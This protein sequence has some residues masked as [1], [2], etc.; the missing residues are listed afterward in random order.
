MVWAFLAV[1]A[2]YR[3]APLNENFQN[4]NVIESALSAKMSFR[5]MV[6]IV[7]GAIAINALLFSQS[8]HLDKFLI[9][10][11][12]WMWAAYID[13]YLVMSRYVYLPDEI[14]A[15]I[16]ILMRPF[17]VFLVSWMAVESHLRW[18]LK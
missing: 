17:V 2:I 4:L 8:R 1:I 14:Y 10:L 11:A 9:F 18:L 15:Q 13:D 16:L 7:V 12:S 6:L 3:F 5:R